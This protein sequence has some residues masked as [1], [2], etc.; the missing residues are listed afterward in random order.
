[1][2]EESD[3]PDNPNGI[4]EH[5]LTWHS[6][7]NVSIHVRHNIY[8]TYNAELNEFI[9]ALDSRQDKKPTLPGLV[10]KK[11]RRVGDPSPSAPPLDAPTWAVI[12]QG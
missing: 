4:V 7:S 12:P 6:T 5:P 11:V 1:M 9:A 10:A 3:D 8:I 2:T